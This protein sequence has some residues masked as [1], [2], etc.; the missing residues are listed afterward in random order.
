M[1]FLCFWTLV[2]KYPRLTDAGTVSYNRSISPTTGIIMKLIALQGTLVMQHASL[3]Q[4][5]QAK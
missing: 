1:A 3:R 4:V 2:F 5:I